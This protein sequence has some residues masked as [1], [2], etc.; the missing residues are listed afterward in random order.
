MA[1]RMTFSTGVEC[2][3]RSSLRKM[4]VLRRSLEEPFQQRR[5]WDPSRLS[6]H[7]LRPQID[8]S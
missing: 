4:A 1:P 6:G 5:R 2:S 8:H 7:S 3:S